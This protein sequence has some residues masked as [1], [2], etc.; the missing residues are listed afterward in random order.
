MLAE[1]RSGEYDIVHSTPEAYVRELRESGA[2][3]PSVHG[4]LNA[5]AVGCYTS[6]IRIKQQHRRLENE[7]FAV[8]R[9][10][11]HA[12]IAAGM[13][14]PAAELRE[15]CRDL[16]TAQFHDM[17]PGSSI[18]AMEAS[19]L[20]GR[21]LPA[22]RV[23]EDGEV[24]MV[25]EALLEYRRSMIVLRYAL[26]RRGAEVRLDVLVRWNEPRRML[27]L[28]VPTIFTGA[29]ARFL[30]HTAYGTSELRADGRETVAQ[31]WVCAVSG[32]E[33]PHAFTCINDCIYGSDF[34]HGEIR[35]SLLRSTG[36]AVLPGG[37]DP[38]PMPHD[39]FSPRFDMGE[40]SYT[41]WLQGGPAAGRLAAVHREA[42]ARNERPYALSYF[43]PG[44]GLVPPPQTLAVVDDESI[45]LSVFKQAEASGAGG[46]GDYILRL[47]EPTGQ[48]RRATLRL[49]AQHIEYPLELSG[50]EVR[51]LRY[52]PH[53]GAVA[54]ETLMEGW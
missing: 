8:E 24:R 27:K 39:R 17:L 43:P 29:E 25:V 36:Y 6:Q 51:T 21:P 23:V 11:S 38:D 33:T 34:A 18:R 13:S 26:P 15:A 44:D 30:G 1:E 9:M 48:A 41:F 20:R 52:R 28:S 3:L 54:E 2:R 5:W 49:S 12:A 31:Q 35:L 22:V 32:G 46:C 37:N 16:L 14:Y 47:H 42:A 45:M 53:A 10:A 19:G 50:F 40:R 7:L 4:D